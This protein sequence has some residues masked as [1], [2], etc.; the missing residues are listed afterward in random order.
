MPIHLRQVLAEMDTYEA[1]GEEKKFSLLYAQKDGSLLHIAE[2]SKGWKSGKEGIK[3][4]FGY[5]LKSKGARLIFDHDAKHPRT[6]I[7][8]GI[9]E[10]NGMKVLE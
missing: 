9:L 8:D 3:S 5:N 1:N 10:F 6:I 4:N 7:I 2:A